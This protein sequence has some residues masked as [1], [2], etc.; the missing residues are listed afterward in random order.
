MIGHEEASPMKRPAIPM[1]LFALA[2]VSKADAGPPNIVM[3]IGDDQA[4]TDYGFMGS[5]NVR[6]PHLDKLAAE[7]LVFERGYVPSSLCRPSLATMATGLFPHQHGIMSNDPPY[8]PGVPPA[9]RMK[10]DQYLSDR[11]KMLQTFE[12]NPNLAKLL[13]ASGF[14]SHQSGK[15]WEGNSCRCGF[16]EGMTHGDPAKGGRHGDAGLTIGRRGLQPV[17]DFLDKAGRDAKPFY[18]WYAPMMPHSPHNPPARLLEKYI[19][20]TPSIHVA[21]YWAMCEWFDETVGQLLGKL[22]QN[23]QSADTIVVFLHDN[24]WIQD[25]DSPAYAPRSKQSPYDGGLRTPIVIR[26]PGKVKPERSSALA[27][28]IDLAPTLLKAAGLKPTAEMTGVDLLDRD[29][30]SKRNAV[31]GEVF[32]HTAVDLEK[33]NRNLR[34][35]WVVQ[36][37]WKLIVPNADVEPKQKLELFDLSMDPS[38]DRNLAA[39]R[40]DLLGALNRTLDQWWKP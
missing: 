39:E 10:N 25:P 12:R 14:L 8:P 20:K 5:K 26:W 30:V 37:R 7:S 11:E 23:G 29:E 16:T 4:W 1:I 33:P 24:G 40:P 28:S 27:S 32:L 13:A 21:R 31:F 34:C 2:V 17:F 3:I 6:T 19:S 36:G 35:R 15:W 9:D 18:L 22:E 38:E